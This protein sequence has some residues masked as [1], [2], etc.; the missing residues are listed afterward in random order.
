[1]P[2]TSITAELDTVLT[3][4]SRTDT[5]TATLLAVAGLIAAA[6]ASLL[7][8]G[9]APTPARLV[10]GLALTGLD[11]AAICLLRAFRPDLTPGP[12]DRG[13][14]VWATLTP[15][16]LLTRLD[17]TPTADAFTAAARLIRLSR[18]TVR[19]F[20]RIRTAVDII[21][22]VLILLPLAAATAA[23]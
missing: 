18:M 19:K 17:I 5:N 8:A 11:A 4:Q 7:T 21:T 20:E 22:A 9:P 2:P 1:M 16:E 15:A 14:V 12:D 6:T 13:F 10:V 23:F 3:Q